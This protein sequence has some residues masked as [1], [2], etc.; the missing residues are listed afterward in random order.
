MTHTT[1][2]PERTRT[3][4]LQSAADD[5][6]LLVLLRAGDRKAFTVLIQRHAGALLRLARSFV[7]DESVA[8]EVVQETWL[9]ALDGLEGFE[10]RASLRTW[11]FRILANKARTRIVRDGRNVP[12]SALAGTDAGDDPAVDADR[13]DLGGM[14]KDPPGNWSE[15]NPERLAQG[16]ETRAAIEAAIAE[17]P[18]AQ[19]AVITLRDIEGLETDEICN[20]LSITVTNQRVLLHRARAKVRQVLERHLSGAR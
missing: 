5:D 2:A 18:E 10:G 15:E 4:A 6:A 19:R 1:K 16:V 7:R 12:F 14:W 3:G 11:L 9:A 13:F 8:E 20:L 17:L